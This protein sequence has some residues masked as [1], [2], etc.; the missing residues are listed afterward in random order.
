MSMCVSVFGWVK[1]RV[2]ERAG[3]V[4]GAWVRVRE[5][6]ESDKGWVK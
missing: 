2:C 1:F 6:W 3:R 5:G 4:T